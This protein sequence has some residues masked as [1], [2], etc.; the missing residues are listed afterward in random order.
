MDRR[1]LPG[2]GEAL[3]ALGRLAVNLERVLPAIVNGLR[4]REL[5]IAFAE[6]CTGGEL[7]AHLTTVPGSSNVVVGS[8][9]CYQI[10]AKHKILGLDFVTEENVVSLRTAKAMALAAQRIFGSDIGVATTGYLDTDNPHAFWAMCGP[11]LNDPLK[12][13]HIDGWRID[14]DQADRREFNREM[15]VDAVMEGLTLFRKEVSDG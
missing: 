12:M 5:T 8:A 7:A 15:L 6:S 14:F 3:G 10:A 9:V 11:V 4:A 1:A 2:L 13:Q